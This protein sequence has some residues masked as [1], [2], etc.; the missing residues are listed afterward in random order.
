MTFS[1]T[2]AETLSEKEHLLDAMFSGLVCDL[3]IFELDG[4]CGL[5]AAGGWTSR[6]K[7]EEGESEDWV[8]ELY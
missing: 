6:S 8:L 3:F 5:V 7:D 4:W 1:I 2:L